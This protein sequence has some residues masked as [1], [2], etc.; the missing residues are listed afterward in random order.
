MFMGFFL[1][2]FKRLKKN[3]L[4]KNFIINNGKANYFLPDFLFRKKI[5]NFR[6]KFLKLK[7]K[8]KFE[9]YFFSDKKMNKYGFNV[10]ILNLNDKISFYKELLEE[11]NKFVISHKY[12]NI[13]FNHYSF[14]YFFNFNILLN[15]NLEIYKI[16]IILNLNFILK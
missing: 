6:F 10:C 9:N 1:S 4:I 16:I 7:K 13:D 2:N 8:F 14:N 15:H 3:Y 5:M 12:E 11:E